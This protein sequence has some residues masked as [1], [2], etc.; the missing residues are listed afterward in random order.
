[1]EQTLIFLKFDAIERGMV[2]EVL[3][4]FEKAGLRIENSRFLRPDRPLLEKH[5]AELKERKPTAFERSVRFLAGK[6][7]ILFILSGINAVAKARSIIGPTD[8]LDAPP[9]TIRGD[10]SSDSIPFADSEDRATY[11]LL[12]AADSPESVEREIQLWFNSPEND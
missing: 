3:G 12:H 9:G 5:Y 7:I 4:R 11:N 8:S 2:G 6:P 1:M 10:L